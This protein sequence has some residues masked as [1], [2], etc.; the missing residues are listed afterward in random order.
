MPSRH[1]I[2]I[3]E[4]AGKKEEKGR[5]AESEGKRWC[6]IP[7]RLT[8]LTSG[9]LDS[10]SKR[11]LLTFFTM[12]GSYEGRVKPYRAWFASYLTATSCRV[13]PTRTTRRTRNT[14]RSRRT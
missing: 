14:L 4:K 7:S 13:E 9:G 8:H 3:L 12:S 6:A 10:V 5:L 1:K 2:F 11:P